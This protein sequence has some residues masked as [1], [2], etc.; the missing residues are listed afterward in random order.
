MRGEE[1]E[2]LSGNQYVYSRQREVLIPCER[3]PSYMALEAILVIPFKGGNRFLARL[4]VF[5]FKFRSRFQNMTSF[6]TLFPSEA[7]K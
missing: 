7:Q 5:R 6:R 3:I 1:R 2:S 4:R